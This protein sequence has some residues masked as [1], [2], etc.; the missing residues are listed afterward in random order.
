MTLLSICIPTYVDEDD[1]RLIDIKNLLNSIKLQDYKNIEVVISDHSS[2]DKVESICSKDFKNINIIYLKNE[3]DRGFW[4]SNIN[5]AI[6]SCSGQLIKLMQQ[7]DIFSKETVFSKIVREYENKNF[8]W[9]ICGGI[10]TVDYKLFYHRIIPTYTNDLHKGNNRLGGISSVVIKNIP[11][12][13]YFDNHL[14]WMGDCEYYIRA[15]QKFGIPKIFEDPLIIYKQS[16]RQLTN[17]LSDEIKIREVELVSKKY[18]NK[19]SVDNYDA[20]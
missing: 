8:E 15:Y 1:F 20:S 13:L 17:K 14:N 16:E 4:G 3:I 10:H 7:D 18:S 19:E 2:N 9:A 11:D 6:K 12:K 5:N